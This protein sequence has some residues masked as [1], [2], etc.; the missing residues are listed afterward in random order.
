MIFGGS[1]PPGLSMAL[2]TGIISGTPTAV[3]SYTFTAR[4]RDNQLC[5]GSRTYTIEVTCPTITLGPNLALAGAVGVKYSLNLTASGGQAPYSYTHIGGSAPPGM[6]LA[7]N[8]IL[9]GTPTQAGKFSF[10]IRA[11]DANG[12]AGQ[13]TYSILIS[14]P[15][16]TINP[17]TLPN[18][19]VGFIY[20]Q[21]LTAAAGQG[22]YS[23]FLLSG[24]LP[25]GL[26][27][28]PNGRITGVASAPGS[29]SVEFRATDANGCIGTRTYT[30]TVDCATI[31]IQ[32]GALPDGAVGVVYSQTFSAIGGRGAL[33][34]QI[35]SGAAPPGLTLSPA[36]ELTGAP[37][38]AGSY[39]F[40]LR[41]GDAN[42]CSGSSGYT[43]VINP[44]CPSITVNPNSVPVG[45]VGLP[46]SQTFSATGGTAPYSFSIVDGSLPS[47]VTL[48]SNGELSGAPGT[49]GYLVFRVRATDA[50]GCYG[51]RVYNLIV[52]SAACPAITLNPSSLSLPR[53]GNV[54]N[55]TLSATGGT[56]PYVFSVATGSLPPGLS[57]ASN[58]NLSGAPTTTGSYTF[59]VRATDANGC[60][61]ERTY[62]QNVLPCEGITIAPTGTGVPSGKVGNPYNLMFTASGGAAPY[63]FSLANNSF[64]PPGLTLSTSGLLSGTPTTRGSYS[65]LLTVTDANGCFDQALLFLSVSDLNCPDIDVSPSNL[66][67]SGTTG[68]GYSQT[69]TASGGAGPYSFTV[70][71]GA[72]PPGL[73]LS[74]GG[75]LTGTPTTAGLFGFTVRA[76]DANGCAG[77]EDYQLLINNPA[78]PAITVNPTSAPLPAGT[79]GAA[80]NQA[81]SATGGAAP[82]AF[83]VT[84][85]A[86]PNGLSLASNG[87]LTGSP[88]TNG[89]YSF[90]VR[91]TDAN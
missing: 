29:Y 42:N 73:S 18:G 74:T 30:I 6:M 48:A 24:S 50:N 54:Y 7:S 59:T 21:D 40:T 80:Y 77:V 37:A 15:T 87:N 90:T 75:N 34:Y 22:P 63:T 25:P 62:T 84:L 81:F 10:T 53:V 1:L 52:N 20:S 79:T 71:A 33:E 17:A 2:S 68:A 88:T 45:Q 57:L 31:V 14:C 69:F 64:L 16:I 89:S 70:G 67:G 27:Y 38:S 12:C 11:T 3:G 65:F 78:C 28:S 91:A 49:Q 23:Y 56:A 35:I 32:P 43:L 44:A 13:K 61:G 26:S 66:S 72:L 47:G 9:G 82:Y 4:A 83:F 86:L 58:G 39:N 41:V 60:T 19:R 8:G 5:S 36:G 85:G 55:Q 51:E 46:Y 76:T